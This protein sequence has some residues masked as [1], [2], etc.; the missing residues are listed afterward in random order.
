MFRGSGLRFLLP[1]ARAYRR[2]L[3]LGTLYAIIGAAASAFSPALLGMA[4]DQLSAGVR[5][6]GL[7]KY[8]LG[9]V[10]LSGTLAFFR[11]QL[12]ML[13]GAVAVGVTYT[14]GQ[15]L[16]ARLLQLDQYTLRQYGTGDL[17]SRGTSDFIY[18]WR[19]FSA[20]FQMSAHAIFLLAIGCALMALTSPLLAA[21]VVVMLALSV[22]FQVGLGQRVERAFVRVQRELARMSAF[23]QEHLSAARM[24]AAYSQE[25]PTLAAFDRVSAGY[26]QENLRYVLLSNAITP[27]PNLVVRLAATLVLAIGGIMI[28]QHQL[29]VGQYVQFIVYLGLLSNTA[30]QLSRALE[31]L[32]QGNAAASRIGEV[33]LRQPEVADAPDAINPPIRGALRFEQVGVRHEGRWVLR[34]VTLDVAA[35]TTLGIVGATGAGKST[36]LGL[37]GRVRDPDEG[38]VLIDGYDIR[39]I[40]LATLRRAI[41]Y[42]PQETLLFGMSLRENIAFEGADILDEHI[43]DA[44]RMARLSNDLPQLPQGLATIVGERGTSLSGGQ[45]QRTA[46]AR[47][48]LRDPQLLVLDD[49]LSSVD[50]HTAAQILGELRAA[51]GS[52]TCLIVAQRLAA[53]RDADQIVVLD[54]GRV[55]ER[56]THQSLLAQD[57]LY[58][59]MYRRE[60]QQAEEEREA[61]K[62]TR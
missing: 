42:V 19:F 3:L 30:I 9:L 23:D 55:V 14:M 18:I 32:Q 56:G 16:F 49:A 25:Q 24:L 59:A 34:D 45:K 52:R 29:T 60:L 47:A 10:A 5:A 38:R 15:D 7:V 26:A 36:L 22:S 58:A 2:H 41:G 54:D 44:M 28:I 53:V 11:Y 35:G 50:A 61:D 37:L 43:H 40:G 51:R 31:R 6:D 39:R 12:R 46:I 17:L 48:L 57:G 27:L 21:I 62:M 13:S 20:G 8:A 4:I 33:L 1:Y